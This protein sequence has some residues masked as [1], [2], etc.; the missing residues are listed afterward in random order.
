MKEI[1]TLQFGNYANYI[2]SHYWNF[3]VRILGEIFISLT[4]L[5]IFVRQRIDTKLTLTLL[6]FS[7]LIFVTFVS[8]YRMN[9]SVPRI[10]IVQSVLKWIAISCID[11]VWMLSYVFMVHLSLL[12][13]LTETVEQFFFLLE[14][15]RVSVH[16]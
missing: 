3:Q 8:S 2:G 1:I 13:S 11:T 4:S 14:R 7:P 5:Y 9:Y 15:G 10:P 6:S 16:F 12:S